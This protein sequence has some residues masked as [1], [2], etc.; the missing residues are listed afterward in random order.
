MRTECK[1]N[2]FHTNPNKHYCEIS[3]TKYCN[4]DTKWV[5]F[6]NLSPPVIWS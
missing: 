6:C 5:K 3:E 2:V 4:K 1:K